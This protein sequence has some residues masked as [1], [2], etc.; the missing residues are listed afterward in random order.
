MKFYSYDE[1]LEDSNKLINDIRLSF[2]PQAIVAIARGGMTLGHFIAQGLDLRQIFTLNSI[3][4]EDSKK[5]DDI[6]IFNVPDLEKFERVLLVD[7]IIDSGETMIEI[8]RVLSAK[9]PKTEFQ[10]ATIFYK[11][12]ALLR[13]EFAIR[14][15]NEWIRFFWDI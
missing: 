13:P 14:E 6:V 8:K 15:A 5:L 11:E 10:I 9:F 1:F 2:S 3:H 12:K 4:Y 7:D